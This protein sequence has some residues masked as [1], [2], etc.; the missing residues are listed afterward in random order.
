MLAAKVREHG[1]DLGLAFDGDADRL[2]AI[3]ENGEETDGDYVL[4]I[5]GDAMKRAGKLKRDTVVTTVMANIGF[6]QAA[7]TLGLQTVQT[8]VG[9]RY[10][11][12]EMVRGGYNLGGEQSGHVIFLDHNT[13]GDGILTGLQLV[14]TVVGSGK[15]LSELKRLMRKFPQT[16]VNVRVADKSRFQGNSAIDAAIASAQAAL[17]E[18]GRI[19][20]RPSGTEALIRVM[21]E[22][23]ELAEIERHAAAIADVIRAELA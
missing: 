17:G 14:D 4:C 1:A 2:I 18:S 5:C 19:L 8:A 15:K 9:D 22:G 23:P 3:D 6:F 7:K 13:T 21:A 10:V 16:L 12:E 11:M 20:V